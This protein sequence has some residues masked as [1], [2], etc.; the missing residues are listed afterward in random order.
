MDNTVFIYTLSDPKTGL[1]RYVGKTTNLKQR[2][3]DHTCN[4]KDPT[5]RVNHRFC[6][7]NSLK[8]EG[9]MPVMEVLEETTIELWQEAETFWISSLKFLGL[10]LVNS[11]S[12]GVGGNGPSLEARRKISESSKARWSVHQFRPLRT[13]YQ[14][15]YH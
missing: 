12:G 6:W 2:L 11:N 10:D 9:L 7:I 15:W 13:R 1:V 5:K 4:Y 8:K 3:F 14:S